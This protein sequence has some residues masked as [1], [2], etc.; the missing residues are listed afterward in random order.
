MFLEGWT[1][2]LT[3][4]LVFEIHKSILGIMYSVPESFRLCI[5]QFQG[6]TS[7]RATPG[8]LHLLLARVPGFVPSEFPG[9]RLGAGLLFVIASVRR[10]FIGMPV[11]I[12]GIFF[13]IGWDLIGKPKDIF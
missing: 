3:S 12:K 11:Y 5:S 9:G 6:P 2:A 1:G 13:W 4:N 10:Q 7:P 8:T